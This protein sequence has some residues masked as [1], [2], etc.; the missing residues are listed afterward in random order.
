VWTIG[1][2]LNVTWS[3]ADEP[4]N[5]TNGIGMVILAKSQIRFNDAPGG[6]QDPLASGF[7]I[8]LGTIEITVP[9]VTPADDYEVVLFGDSGNISQ[10]FTISY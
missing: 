6:F 10:D 3:L 7:D 2:K 5:I 4:V 1:T 8:R 9:D